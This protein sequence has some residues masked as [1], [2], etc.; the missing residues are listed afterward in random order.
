MGLFNKPNEQRVGNL[1]S[2]VTLLP[3]G[4]MPASRDFAVFNAFLERDIRQMIRSGNENL[5]EQGSLALANRASRETA[6]RQPDWRVNV[7]VED[8]SQQW[9]VHTFDGREASGMTRELAVM[10]GAVAI[11]GLGVL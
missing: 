6:A 7:F 1:L 2:S 11:P 4:V 5:D 9:A 10:F 3:W 8:D